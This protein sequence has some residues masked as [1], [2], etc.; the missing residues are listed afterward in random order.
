MGFTSCEIVTS[1]G[2]EGR[3]VVCTA[4]VARGATLLVEDKV[5]FAVEARVQRLR[6]ALCGCVACA[7]GD[8]PTVV[9]EA[10]AARA[11]KSAPLGRW[12]DA[13][14]KLGTASASVGV[15]AVAAASRRVDVDRLMDHE[16]DFAPETL[17]MFDTVSLH[18][19]PVTGRDAAACRRAI[20]VAAAHGVV[21]HDTDF[22]GD[23]RL[24][25]EGGL[26]GELVGTVLG[27]HA[28][29]FNHADD[30]SAYLSVRLA[31]G[32]SPEVVV[33]AS[34]TL[35]P[36]D[37]AY[38]FAAAPR[39][40]D[41]RLDALIRAPPAAAEG[42]KRPRTLPE[43]ALACLDGAYAD[44]KLGRLQAAAETADDAREL[45]SRLPPTHG[46]RV[47]GALLDVVVACRRGP[48]YADIAATF[49]RDL[50]AVLDAHDGLAALAADPLVLARRANRGDA[51]RTRPSGALADAPRSPRAA[52]Q[53]GPRRRRRLR[54]AGAR[55]RAR[56]AP[57][58]RVRGA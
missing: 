51:A 19:A 44:L 39:D 2:P 20:C 22:R 58:A 11:A 53:A 21:V 28:A 16:A 9:C 13:V 7:P 46:F 55:A 48:A 6:C 29:A 42:E 1:P 45:F 3:H 33:R 24:D 57:A 31:P 37:A 30:A 15:S 54:R 47:H 5:V 18:L 26:G 34:R 49:A 36:G 14:T 17:A 32:R 52:A 27:E 38:F 50:L 56:R 10:C 43:E 4:P 12:L 8:A 35:A 23:A 41:A 25:G 40:D